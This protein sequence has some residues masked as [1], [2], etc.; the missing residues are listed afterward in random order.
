MA[1]IS[2]IDLYEKI[3]A[4]ASSKSI[5]YDELLACLES[6]IAKEM[7]SFTDISLTPVK[8][9]FSLECEILQQLLKSLVELEQLKFL[10]SL[11]LIYGANTRLSAWETK[12]QNREVGTRILI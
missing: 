1:R 8:A 12:V 2:L 11:A 6:L 9:T 4:T 10:P 3:Y 7:Q 5:K